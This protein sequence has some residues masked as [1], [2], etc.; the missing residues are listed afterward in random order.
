MLYGTLETPH[1]HSFTHAQTLEL[2]FIFE[3]LKH[4][5][6]VPK[7]YPGKHRTAHENVE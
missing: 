1:K 7:D 2:D 5:N 4:A 3:V 6:C